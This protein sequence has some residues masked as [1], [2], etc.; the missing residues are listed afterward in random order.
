AYYCYMVNLRAPAVIK[1]KFGSL[2]TLLENKYYLDKFNELV[3][4][5]GAYLLGLGLWNVGDRDLIDNLFVNG[6]VRV[7]D[8]FSRVARAWQ[9]GFIYHY[10]FVMIIG[11]LGFLIYFMPFPFA[12]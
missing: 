12:K 1:E 3:L 11:V 4:V 7:I 8:W 5:R 9:T 10:A 2:Y 6:S